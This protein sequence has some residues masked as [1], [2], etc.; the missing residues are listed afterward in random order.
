MPV[1]KGLRSEEV[2]RVRKVHRKQKSGSTLGSVPSVLLLKSVLW[3]QASGIL[4]GL[5]MVF[6][7]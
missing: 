6:S 1:L 5:F 7:L 4:G 3:L 2:F